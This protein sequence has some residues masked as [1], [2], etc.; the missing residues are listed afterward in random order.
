MKTEELNEREVQRIM[1]IYE[2]ISSSQ[3]SVS[4]EEIQRFF[5]MLRVSSLLVS[6]PSFNSNFSIVDGYIKR[7]NNLDSSNRRI[8]AMINLK[9]ADNFS[10][11]CK[12][13]YIKILAVSGSNS[14]LSASW[15]DDIDIF[16]ISK[17]DT[18]WLFIF[19]ALIYA[20]IF[21]WL[22]KNYP[23][24][25]IS[26]VMDEVYAFRCYTIPKDSLFASDALAAK[27]LIGENDYAMLLK[28]SRWM[29][30]FLS[31]EYNSKLK[32]LD[33]DELTNKEETKVWRRFLNALAY[34]FLS[35]YIRLKSVILNRQLAKKGMQSAIFEVKS[36]IDHLMY[37]SA[38]YVTLK[39]LYLKRVVDDIG[40]R[41]S[42][43]RF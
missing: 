16:C 5:P 43:T 22:G 9:I 41:S 33:N 15:S 36:G 25:S 13:N 11:Y 27:V 31:H 2:L 23:P 21:S 3:K 20:R 18:M 35:R 32:E 10:R 42:E 4:I 39:R 8:R 38:F 40:R 19:K 6:T 1:L 12:S 24:I 28:K 7:H 37:E 29:E 14:Y 26:C 30:R 34:I 17:R